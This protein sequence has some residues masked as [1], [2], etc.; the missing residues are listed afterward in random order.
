M[1]SENWVDDR[2]PKVEA[3]WVQKYNEK[4]E[5]IINKYPNPKKP[6]TEYN[7]VMERN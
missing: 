2:P 1:L 3:G 7:K 5:E 4:A 6:Y